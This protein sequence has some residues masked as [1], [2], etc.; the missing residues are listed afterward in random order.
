MKLR[1]ICFCIWPRRAKSVSVCF[2]DWSARIELFYFCLTLPFALSFELYINR[3]SI[4]LRTLTLTPTSN[5]AYCLTLGSI[6]FFWFLSFFLFNK[7]LTVFVRF[8]L[9]YKLSSK[10]KHLVVGGGRWLLYILLYCVCFVYWL[11]FIHSFFWFYY[12]HAVA[13]VLTFQCYAK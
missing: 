6:S 13:T 11:A 10:V 1:Y 7:P 9:N 2:L 4:H 3:W 8:R 12:Q 5:F